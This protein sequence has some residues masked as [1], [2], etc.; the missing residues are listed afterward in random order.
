MAIKSKNTK[1]I[2]QKKIIA[3]VLATVMFFAS[4]IFASQ[5]INGFFNFS[6]GV[7]VPEYT[8]TPAF[9]DIMNSVIRERIH[10]S[11]YEGLSDIEKFSLTNWG[12]SIIETY[13]IQKTEVEK[14][15]DILEK[16][17][18]EVYYDA[19]NRYRYSLN[20]NDI[21]Y[22][23]SYNGDLIS[24]DDFNSLA[25]VQD[26]PFYV[27]FTV[28]DVPPE[29]ESTSIVP[30]SQEH[31]E[32]VTAFVA[33]VT[34]EPVRGYYS[35]YES[36]NHPQ[37]IS[38]ISNA[39]GI[40]CEYTVGMCY[41][42]IPKDEALKIIEKKRTDE[43]EQA[44]NDSSSSY[45]HTTHIKNVNYALIYSDGRV[46]TNCGIAATDAEEVI[47][48]KLNSERFIE[49]VT[50]NGYKLYKGSPVQTTETVFTL[51]RESLFDDRRF[52]SELKTNRYLEGKMNGITAAYFAF[53]DSGEADSLSI[54][55]RSYEVFQKLTTSIPLNLILLLITLLIAYIACVYLLSVAGITENG[56]RLRFWDKI[57]AE[58]SYSIGIAVMV[59]IAVIE[60]YLN[61]L[62][63][64]RS[65]FFYDMSND[66]FRLSSTILKAILPYSMILEGFN[67]SAFF[68]I[69]TG[70]TASFI[71]N[72]RNK[73]FWRHTIICFLLKPIRKAWQNLCYSIENDYSE[74]KRTK[75]KVIS[76][77]ICVVF[78]IF[79]F[80][81]LIL[82]G[83]E[84]D[85]EGSVFAIFFAILNIAAIIFCL[86]II[87]SLDRIFTA[88]AD[89][90]NGN[91]NCEIDTAFMPGFMK[92]FAEDVLTMQDG[93]QNAVESA[94]KDQRM[95][96]ELITNVSHDLKTPLTSI[97][98]YVDLL[99]KCEIDG[100]DANRYVSILDEKAQKMKKL[101]EDLVEAS[102]ASSGAV[103][104]HPV[105]INL[106]EFATQ[107]V[108][109]YEDELKKKNIEIMLKLPEN[110]VMITADSQKISRIVENLV[111]NIR[112][113]AMEGTRAYVEVMGGDTYGV[114]VFKNIS[115]QA[116]D[117][118]PDELTHRFVRG[119]A[120]RSSEGNGLGLSIAKDLC[121]L[122]NGKLNIQ[123]DGDLFKVTVIFPIA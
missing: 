117:I 94:V 93:L 75:F 46:I 71:R 59:G 36:G 96:A 66:A 43:L 45:F 101:I 53:S 23:F 86:V 22:F 52:E 79:N 7:N 113:Y 119:D 9:R 39:L 19:Q 82:C 51:L 115:K 74:G 28:V 24:F 37:H 84:I 47:L 42:E 17:G 120:S 64:E 62:R 72:I 60:V 100:E 90:K 1:N 61:L 2:K 18:I 80:I 89:I 56:I 12:K 35:P 30:V 38:D 69:W 15:Y 14:S 44:F 118:S 50:A 20:Y 32:P 103:E 67:V 41:G 112:K 114:M 40:I 25:Y 49:G 31:G 106:C 21:Q 63:I 123:I 57:P 34:D 122:Q 83:W 111:S 107:T 33:E 29:V 110:P 88:V 95:K 11:Q 27:P 4:G 70:L 81:G 13:D 10:S 92:H 58:I 99:K 48:E 77:V 87:S 98:T 91:L 3:I 105:K 26:V 65:M 116:L 76:S 102:K 78:F 73:S 8:Q 85:S 54:S 108:G 121:E 6:D 104:L 5:F 55:E 109:E 16:S 97:V 68:M